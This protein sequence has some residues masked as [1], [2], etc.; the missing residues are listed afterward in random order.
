MISSPTS[1]WERNSPVAIGVCA[2]CCSLPPKSHTFYRRTIWRRTHARRT[3]RNGCGAYCDDPIF[4]VAT[5]T[6]E[7]DS[8]SANSISYFND[9][10]AGYRTLAVRNGDEYVINGIKQFV[11]HINHAR[12]MFVFVRTDPTDLPPQNNSKLNKRI[13]ID[14]DRNATHPDKISATL[15]N[16]G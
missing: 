3:A 6:T 4:L 14:C 13:F 7:P 11:S 1:S 8:G 5:A 2:A 12:P 10:N 15:A 9:L 16:L